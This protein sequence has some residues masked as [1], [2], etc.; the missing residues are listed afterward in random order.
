METD[1]IKALH[2][3]IDG[4][5]QGVGFRY[6]VHNFAESHALA[7]WV[8]NR[9]EDQVEVFAE[10]SEANLNELLRALWRGPGSARVINVDYEWIPAQRQHTRFSI[11]PSEF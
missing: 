5:V 10:G 4:H 9:H 2:A 3:I 6:F 7:G 1:E 8:R 11:L